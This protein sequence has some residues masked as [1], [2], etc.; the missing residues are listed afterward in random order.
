MVVGFSMFMVFQMVP[1]LVRNPVP[2][3]FGGET[4]RPPAMC[5]SSLQ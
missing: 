3:G 4:R 5:S 1:V 2:L